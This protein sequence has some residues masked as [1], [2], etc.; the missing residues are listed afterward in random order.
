MA[1]T[2]KMNHVWDWEIWTVFVLHFFDMEF[3][4][5]TQSVK[6]RKQ[7]KCNWWETVGATLTRCFF[8]RAKVWQGICLIF[9]LKKWKWVNLTLKVNQYILR[10]QFVKYKASLSDEM[11]SVIMGI[12]FLSCWLHL[13]HRSHGRAREARSNYIWQG[14]E[15][16]PAKK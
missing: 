5:G 14:D 10:W 2:D 1:T 15:G 6:G 3:F 11:G 4:P 13:P 9:Y 8:I 12:L 16:E 7:N